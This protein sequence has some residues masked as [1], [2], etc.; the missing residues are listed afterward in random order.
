MSCT[1][2]EWVSHL[3]EG[4]NGQWMAV[5]GPATT[6]KIE[7]KTFTT[8]SWPNVESLKIYT[9][10]ELMSGRISAQGRTAI[11][12]PYGFAPPPCGQNTPS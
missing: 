5:M 10:H 1:A 11:H 7:E 12:G 9:G 2:S 4:L 3:D 6:H 8:I